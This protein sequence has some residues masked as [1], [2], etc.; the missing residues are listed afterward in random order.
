LL[1]KTPGFQTSQSHRNGKAAALSIANEC[2]AGAPSNDGHAV[3]R[4]PTADAQSHELPGFDLAEEWRRRMSSFHIFDG[5]S[6]PEA[7]S[8]PF[9]LHTTQQ[10]QKQRLKH[11]ERFIIMATQCLL[12]L[13]KIEAFAI[14]CR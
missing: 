1:P 5:Q 4:D 14:G 12:Y 8:R 2:A 9:S 3:K 11:P 7:I 6:H 10:L 13:V